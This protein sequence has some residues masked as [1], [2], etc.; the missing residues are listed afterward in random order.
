MEQVDRAPGDHIRLVP[1]LEEYL[2]LAEEHEADP[3]GFFFDIG[4][5]IET[6]VRIGGGA[7]VIRDFLAA[8]LVDHMHVVMVL[9]GRGVRLWVG[10]EGLEKDYEVE[11]TS[12]PSGVTHVTFTVRD[13]SAHAGAA[14]AL[15]APR[16]PDG[17]PL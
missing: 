5:W 6:L 11:A 12:S 9:L 1:I 8:G 13:R 17:A 7:T 10:L 16:P 2:R 15:R 3:D 14:D 4:A